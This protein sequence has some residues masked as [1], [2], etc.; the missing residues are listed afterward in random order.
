MSSWNSR[1]RHHS[2]SCHHSIIILCDHFEIEWKIYSFK[3]CLAFN[4][5]LE[6]QDDII[7]RNLFFFVLF[8]HCRLTVVFMKKKRSSFCVFSV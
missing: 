3:R 7:F 1:F 6:F 4:S 2:E 8:L 5:N